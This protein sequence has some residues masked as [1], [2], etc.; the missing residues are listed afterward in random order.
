M[1]IEDFPE[2]ANSECKN[3]VGSD[4]NVVWNRGYVKYCCL[5][6]GVQCSRD[7]SC[8][9]LHK[10]AAEDPDFING[11]V[12][13]RKQTCLKNHG[14]ETWNNRESSAE[15]C[16]SRYGVKTPMQHEDFCKKSMQTREDKYGKGNM[17]NYKKTAAT[18][19]RL[20]GHRSVW[21]NPDI[22][23]KCIDK[24]IELYGSPNPGSKY[25]LDGF[26]FDSKPEVAFY[27]WLRDHD[28]DFT[29]KPDTSFEYTH[30]GKTYRY[31]PDFIV[32]GCVVEIKGDHFFEDCDPTKKMVNPFLDIQDGQMESKHQCMIKND[33]KIITSN[34]YQQ[35]LDYV[36]VKYGKDYIKNLKCN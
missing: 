4:C 29:C 23:K 5:K 27:I 34:E 31:Y 22:H 18:C 28:I 15:T 21:G 26:K 8:D 9:T 20:Y 7:K 2:C 13:R 30:E 17:T 11:I 25:E 19:L 3:K 32:E 1:G 35:Y 10:H 24:T 12:K 14:S 16:L 33:V 6:C 36:E